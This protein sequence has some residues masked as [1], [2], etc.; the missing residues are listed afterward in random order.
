M[1]KMDAEKRAL[2]EERAAV[3][4]L[5]TENANLRA[6]L[7]NGPSVKCQMP[8]CD[9]SAAFNLRCGNG[10]GVC[11]EHTE[12]ICK[13][14]GEHTADLV[15]VNPACKEKYCKRAFMRCGATES[16]RAACLE[17]LVVEEKEAEHRREKE[18]EARAIAARGV[19]VRSA[20][21][22]DAVALKRPCCGQPMTDFTGC[23]AIECD[24]PACKKHFC[25]ICL[26]ESFPNS[27]RAH[28]HVVGC[29]RKTFGVESYFID[30][31][32]RNETLQRAKERLKKHHESLQI[33]RLKE[34]CDGKNIVV[35]AV[36]TS[37]GW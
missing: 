37:D 11:E 26:K 13:A 18:D 25:A 19:E 6:A 7:E 8:Y 33:K 29:N 31:Q 32:Y 15:C 20:D 3:A 1:E 10:H 2:E 30:R 16:V 17:R 4:R 21:I 27:Q 5:R 34:F 22:E 35:A 14:I 36:P 12:Y 24:N 9:E 28:N 23:L